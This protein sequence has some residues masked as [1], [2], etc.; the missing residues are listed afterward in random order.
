[1]HKFEYGEHGKAEP[2]LTEMDTQTGKRYTF[3]NVEGFDDSGNTWII[4]E[5]CAVATAKIQWKNGAWRRLF[6]QS[7]IEFLP[8]CTSIW[9]GQPRPLER[10]EEIE[11]KTERPVE[12]KTS[13][14]HRDR[15]ISGSGQKDAPQKA[16]LLHGA[17]RV[18]SWLARF[19]AD[20]NHI[21]RP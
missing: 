21:A 3:R 7:C 19:R 2:G 12:E 1:M 6:E 18:S 5:F 9:I 17:S 10:H 14:R 4:P 20:R 16:G 13:D 11:T 15:Q 8:N